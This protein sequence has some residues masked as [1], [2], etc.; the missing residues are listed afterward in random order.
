MGAREEGIRE[1]LIRR[2]E[3]ENLLGELYTRRAGKEK[4]ISRIIPEYSEEWEND[5]YVKGSDKKGDEKMLSA[6]M[7][8]L[9]A[10]REDLKRNE[11]ECFDEIEGRIGALRSEAGGEGVTDE[12]EKRLVSIREQGDRLDQAAVLGQK[13]I[14][15]TA[16]IKMCMDQALKFRRGSGGLSEP[17]KAALRGVDLLEPVLRD[18]YALI[19]ETGVQ[20][21]LRDKIKYCQLG[22]TDWVWEVFDYDIVGLITRLFH[23][24]DMKRFSEVDV[25][26]IDLRF[27]VYNAMSR[28]AERRGVLVGDLLQLYE[29]TDGERTKKG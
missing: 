13:I 8:L 20:Q 23:R 25:E 19:G 22:G 9:A 6:E 14:R 17:L 11:A 21:S 18:F 28:V 3:V 1:K 5:P 7:V 24:P 10:E 2:G 15:Q 29:E 26:L 12:L 27:R 4:H 16:F